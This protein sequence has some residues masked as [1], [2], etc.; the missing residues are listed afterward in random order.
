M[1]CRDQIFLNSLPLTIKLRCSSSVNNDV[2]TMQ[3][4]Y[5]SRNTIEFDIF[6]QPI[7]QTATAHSRAVSCSVKRTTQSVW[8]W[9]LSW[10]TFVI[11]KD[12]RRL[13]AADNRINVPF[14]FRRCQ[15]QTPPENSLRMDKEHPGDTQVC[16]CMAGWSSGT[17]LHRSSQVE[18]H[19]GREKLRVQQQTT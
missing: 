2:E 19:R 4:R 12:K 10:A 3:H 1:R 17:T 16:V 13:A 5:E 9:R 6:D 15:L 14:S 7:S 8:C 18:A 11:A